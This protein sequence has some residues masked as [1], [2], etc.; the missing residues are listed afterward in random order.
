MA[1]PAIRQKATAAGNICTAAPAADVAA[2]LYALGSSVKLKSI[3][4]ERIVPLSSFYNTKRSY[5]TV[6]EKDEILT[7]ILIPSLQKGEGTGYTRLSRRKSQDI[8]KVMVGVRLKTEKGLITSAS[9]SLGAVNAQL[10]HGT[11]TEK[12]IIGMNEKESYDYAFTHFPEEAQLHESY[13][14][15]YKK[16]VLPSTLAETI[17][18]AFLS[19]KE[20]E[21]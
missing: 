18:K 5:S 15:E 21:R 7:S 17:K 14:T 11:E 10:V 6:M 20:E 9:I 8:A 19:I 13:Y 12:A 3:R 4:G 2:M 16:A 1:S